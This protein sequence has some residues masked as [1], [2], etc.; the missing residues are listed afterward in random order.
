MLGQEACNIV[1]HSQ[2]FFILNTTFLLFRVFF[3]LIHLIEKTLTGKNNCVKVFAFWF[4]FQ[5]RNDMK[6]IFNNRPSGKVVILRKVWKLVKEDTQKARKSLWGWKILETI[7]FTM[8]AYFLLEN[9]T[10]FISVNA[11]H[12]SCTSETLKSII[13]A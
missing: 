10:I 3:L 8:L 9:F 5:Y 1:N 12:L 13:S 2:L 6:E 11:F 7:S 4:N